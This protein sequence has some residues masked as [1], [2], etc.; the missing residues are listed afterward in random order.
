[1]WPP[2]LDQQGG[3]GDMW[4]PP[5][6]LEPQ[7]GPVDGYYEMP[8]ID[9]KDLNLNLDGQPLNIPGNPSYRY[10]QGQPLY[11]PGQPMYL[12]GQPIDIPDQPFG[13]PEQPCSDCIYDT[14]DYQ[15]PI[16][17]QV[18]PDTAYL[19]ILLFAKF[20]QCDCE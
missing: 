4:P 1:M 14:Y 6:G 17:I 12:P 5:G 11:G 10:M 7:G 19:F 20:V 13:N 15:L 8:Q 3:P 9:V 2:P 16:G 18:N